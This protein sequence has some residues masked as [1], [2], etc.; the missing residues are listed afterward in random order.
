[1]NNLTPG[2]FDF[3]LREINLQSQG[4]GFIGKGK[5]YEDYVQYWHGDWPGIPVAYQ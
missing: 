2:Q 4:Y 1:M 3:V 5:S